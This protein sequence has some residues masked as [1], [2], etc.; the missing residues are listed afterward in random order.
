ME[1]E[2]N[3]TCN[4]I[5]LNLVG[6]KLILFND[7]ELYIRN[8][9]Y[10]NLNKSFTQ[11]YVVRYLESNINQTQFEPT[12]DELIINQIENAQKIEEL[13]FH[14]K[15]YQINIWLTISF[16]AV[17]IIVLVVIFIHF[18]N[19]HKAIE[20]NINAKT[21]ECFQSREGGVTS[22]GHSTPTENRIEVDW[23]A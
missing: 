21:Q 7:C 13:T 8:E 15:S 11:K 5:T 2:I 6:T 16:I 4:E 1:I 17:I 22:P 14:K 10:K 20:L 3:S 23:S 19:K 18:T 12:F 9:T